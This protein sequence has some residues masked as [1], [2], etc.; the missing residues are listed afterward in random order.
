MSAHTPW[1]QP[2]PAVE[3]GSSIF[4]S[5]WLTRANFQGDYRSPEAV[6]IV[7][8]RDSVGRGLLCTGTL[9]PSSSI[10]HHEQMSFLS[11]LSKIFALGTVEA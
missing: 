10:V 9:Q 8:S 7:L 4:S 11:A 3:I 5:I 6:L 1:I 2:I